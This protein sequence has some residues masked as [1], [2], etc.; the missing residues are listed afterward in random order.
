MSQDLTTKKETPILE[1]DGREYLVY[2][3]IQCERFDEYWVQGA[4][5]P[6]PIAQKVD[7]MSLQDGFIAVREHW[8]VPNEEQK[9]A[10]VRPIR[11]V[12]EAR[13]CEKRMVAKSSLI[14]PG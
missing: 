9:K 14:T 10:G 6:V 12:L 8:I 1:L 7:P 13:S 3:I 4:F 11:Y 5:G 2:L